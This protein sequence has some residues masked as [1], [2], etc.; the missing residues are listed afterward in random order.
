ML[1]ALAILSGILVATILIIA[2]FEI[3]VAWDRH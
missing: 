3:K 1:T 2:V